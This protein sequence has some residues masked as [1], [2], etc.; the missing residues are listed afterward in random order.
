MRIKKEEKKQDDNRDQHLLSVSS[1]EIFSG[2]RKCICSNEIKEIDAIETALPW[3]PAFL[4]LGENTSLVFTGFGGI[5]GFF[6]EDD[7]LKC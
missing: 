1:N 3:L 6:V 4:A 7:L 5:S 2:H